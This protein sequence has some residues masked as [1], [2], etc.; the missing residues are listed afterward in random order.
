M[1]NDGLG[2]GRGSHEDKGTDNND[3]DG[4]VFCLHSRW[5]GTPSLARAQD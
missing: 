1:D 3:V 4:T 2:D 5:Q